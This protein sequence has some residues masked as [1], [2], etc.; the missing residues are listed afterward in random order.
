MCEYAVDT[1]RLINDWISAGAPLEWT[2]ANS[3]P[4]ASPEEAEE[5]EDE[6]DN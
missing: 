5:A 3:E 1:E 6:T 4:S 2:P